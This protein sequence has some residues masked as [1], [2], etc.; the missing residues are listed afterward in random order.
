MMAF[1]HTLM[2]YIFV[3]TMFRAGMSSVTSIM[4]SDMHLNKVGV[5]TPVREGSLRR[6]QIAEVSGEDAPTVGMSR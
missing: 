4:S 3:N 1:D 5:W 2:F 6:Q